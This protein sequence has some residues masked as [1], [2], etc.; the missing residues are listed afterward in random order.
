MKDT[1]CNP[2]CPMYR[3]SRFYFERVCND[4]LECEKVSLTAFVTAHDNISHIMIKKGALVHN[5]QEE[6][7]LRALPR[8]MRAN[9]TMKR[10]L[11]TRYSSRFKS[12]ILQTQVLDKCVSADVLSP[13]DPDASPTAPGVSHYSISAG[14]PLPGFGRST[15]S[16]GS[17]L[18]PIPSWSSTTTDG[19]SLEPSSNP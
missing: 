11:V 15:Y 1:I 3:D 19:S 2:G 10:E 5:S 12:N 17:L 13:L 9:A 6:M 8:E 16:A 7:L 14:V 4:Q 18:L